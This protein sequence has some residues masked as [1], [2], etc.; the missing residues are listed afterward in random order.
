MTLQ[1]LQRGDPTRFAALLAAPPAARAP[2]ATLYAFN[3]EIAR[4][5]WVTKEPMIAEM[6]LQWWRDA[7]EDAARGTVRAHEVMAPLA[8]LMAAHDLPL[9]T[10]DRMVEARRWDIYSD[11]FADQTAFD[12][13]LMDT[14]G[15]LMWLSAKALGAG[16]ASEPALRDFGWAAALAAYLQAVSA[17]VERGRIPLLDGRDDGITALATRGLARLAAARKGPIDPAARPAMLAGWQAQALL[18]MAA[19]D[20]A[21]VGDGTLQLSEFSRRGR[22]LWQA[23]THRI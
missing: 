14:G 18:T 15:G 21:R 4:A 23:F 8:D 7:L 2:L 10:L 9:E 6:R 16:A 11:A 3:L 19:R 17:L 13:Y 22:L 1:S 20:P 12:D 5:P